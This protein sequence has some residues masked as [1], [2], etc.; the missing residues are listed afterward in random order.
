L[1]IFNSLIICQLEKPL[2]YNSEGLFSFALDPRYSG[3]ENE[4][5]FVPFCK[6]PTI[7]NHP[8]HHT[9]PHEC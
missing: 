1:D 7:S 3:I 8:C 6:D 4:E 2:R 5:I 9:I